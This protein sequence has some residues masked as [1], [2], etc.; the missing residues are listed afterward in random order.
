MD[1]SRLLDSETG[2]IIVSIL[3]GLGLS[4]LFRK[5][6]SDRNCLAFYGVPED[7]ILNKIFQQ[8]ENCFRYQPRS[9]RCN[10]DVKTIVTLN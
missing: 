4:T 7:K 9:T 1:L 3:L 2:K 5:L 6:C 10:A 8:D